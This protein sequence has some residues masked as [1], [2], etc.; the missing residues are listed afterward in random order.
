MSSSSSPSDSPQTFPTHEH[1]NADPYATLTD[2][3]R[4]LKEPLKELITNHEELIQQYYTKFEDQS[5]AL[6]RF[7]SNKLTKSET[8]VAQL[9]RLNNALETSR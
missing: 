5:V 6:G 1:S 9:E 3:L 8:V 4:Q 7:S 2:K